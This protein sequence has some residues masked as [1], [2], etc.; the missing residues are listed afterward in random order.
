MSCVA[1]VGGGVAA[2][3]R[4]AR[5]PRPRVTLDGCGLA[6]ARACLE[7]EAIPVTVAVDLSRH[8]VRKR[9]DADFLPEDA[10]R[11]WQSVIVPAIRVAALVPPMPFCDTP[12]PT[13][14]NH[15]LEPR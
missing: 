9:N 7:R 12:T 13:G 15:E 2:I 3:L 4:R 10:E 6:C 11:L 5:A 8:D 1:G 14:E